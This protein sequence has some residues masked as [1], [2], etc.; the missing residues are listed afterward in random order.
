[1]RVGRDGRGRGASHAAPSPTRHPP[2]R[3]C[4]R[5]AQR[6]SNSP[7]RTRIPYPTRGRPRPP[8]A[9]PPPTG[10]KVRRLWEG[11]PKAN[12]DADPRGG[13]KT[14]RV[15]HATSETHFRAPRGHQPSPPPSLPA[16]DVGGGRG[17]R[18]CRARGSGPGTSRGGPG[19]GSW[20][21]GN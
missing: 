14:R 5:R 16:R 1:M 12:V 8:P 18:E 15:S 7:P 6:N 10:A 2:A 21:G 20:R 4:F 19:G 3:G 13:K 17:R 11:P 9:D